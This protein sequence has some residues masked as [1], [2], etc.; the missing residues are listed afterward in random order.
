MSIILTAAAIVTTVENFDPVTMMML[1]KVR[2]TA[3]RTI[4]M[5]MMLM[6]IKVTKNDGP[7]C[8]N[9]TQIWWPSAAMIQAHVFITAQSVTAFPIVR[10]VT[11]KV[12]RC[13]VS[14]GI[15]DNL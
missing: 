9:W 11:M 10:M 13:V 14:A 5:M 12:L 1:P 6:M 4:I 8:A 3:T 2:S 15:V 7:I